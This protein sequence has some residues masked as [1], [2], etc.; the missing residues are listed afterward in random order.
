MEPF[1]QVAELRILATRLKILSLVERAGRVKVV[2]R[3]QKDIPIN[4]FMHLFENYAQRVELI[5]QESDAFFY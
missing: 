5:P 4:K 1:L 3:N 2:F